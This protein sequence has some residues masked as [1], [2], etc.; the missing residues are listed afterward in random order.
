MKTTSDKMTVTM[1]RVASCNKRCILSAPSEIGTLQDNIYRYSTRNIFQ[2]IAYIIMYN[3][4]YQYKC[5]QVAL[6]EFKIDLNRNRLITVITKI[7]VWY[8]VL[9]IKIL[10]NNNVYWLWLQ[11]IKYIQ[12]HLNYQIWLNIP[13]TYVKIVCNWECWIWFTK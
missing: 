1:S 12:N 2:R 13:Y 8:F 10:Y 7:I 9:M 11:S 6:R 5:I 4:M 3:T